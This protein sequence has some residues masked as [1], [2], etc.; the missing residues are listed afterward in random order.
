MIIARQEGETWG[1]SI[2][3]RLAVDLQ[4]EF[5]GIGGVL[6][7]QSWRVKSFYE[8]YASQVKLAPLVREL[9]EP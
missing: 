1:K 9:G 3:E 7:T 6:S 2:V 4:T 5:P 8:M